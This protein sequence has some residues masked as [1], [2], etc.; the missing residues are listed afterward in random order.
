MKENQVYIYGHELEEKEIRRKYPYSMRRVDGRVIRCKRFTVTFDVLM[1]YSYR[2]Q[3]YSIVSWGG[4]YK[5]VNVF[6]FRKSR[7]SAYSLPF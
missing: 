2:E 4:I 7:I 1:A 3:G 6:V 5:G